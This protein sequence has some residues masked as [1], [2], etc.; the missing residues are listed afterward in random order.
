[1]ATVTITFETSGACFEDDYSEELA[2]VLR[3]AQD[4][5]EAAGEQAERGHDYH[6]A[7]RDTNG[8][9]IGRVLISGAETL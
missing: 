5:L 3:R 6:S 8:N 4:R 7:L 2:R 1:M 9:Y